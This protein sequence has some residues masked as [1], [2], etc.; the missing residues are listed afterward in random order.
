MPTFLGAIKTEKDEIISLNKKL[1][2]LNKQFNQ[3]QRR[4][5]KTQS[6]IDD[7]RLDDLSSK[8]AQVSSRLEYLEK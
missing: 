1:I 6:I 4:Y 5:Y 7:R 3:V 2:S 8:M